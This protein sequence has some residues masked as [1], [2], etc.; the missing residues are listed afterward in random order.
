MA[1]DTP[2][3]SRFSSFANFR[4]RPVADR[5]SPVTEPVAEGEAA[6]LAAAPAHPLPPDAPADLGSLVAFAG[7]F[8]GIGFNTIFRP[9]NTATPTPMPGPV[10]PANPRDNVLELNLTEEVLSFSPNLGQIPNRGSDK[11]GD[12]ILNGIPYLQTINDIANAPVP[13]GIHFEPGL[14]LHVPSTTNPKEPATLV[15]MAS[16]PH[17]TT[18]VAQGNLIATVNGP[19]AGKNIAPVDIT[20]FVG[21]DQANKI[22]FN[23]QKAALKNTPRIPQD[24]SKFIA[25]G[26]ITQKILDDPNEVLRQHI[27]H[28][29][30]TKTTV[31]GISTNPAVLLQDGPLTQ[32]G[33]PDPVLAPK[34]GG[35]PA[36]IAFLEGVPNPPASA[37][38]PNAQSFQMDA[39]FWIETVVYDVEVPEIPSGLPAVNCPIAGNPKLPVAPSFVASIPFQPGRRFAGGVVKV[40]TTQIQYSQKVVLNFNGLSWPHVSVATLVPADPIR[41]P[42]SL[43]PLT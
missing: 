35:G 10:D 34:F 24:L 43:L 2:I 21:G 5:V 3:T 12:V 16:I 36:N 28:Q 25:A 27:A 11:Q 41:I 4:I 7:T 15:R 31:V 42:A 26:T 30:I 32:K 37:Q 40:E 13:Q 22:P 1:D 33:K 38:G 19:F 6:G 9:D 20:P 39:V 23:S 8:R 18:I 17:G 14:W 29:T